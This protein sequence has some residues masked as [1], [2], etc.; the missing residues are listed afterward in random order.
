[1]PQKK[2]EGGCPKEPKHPG[3]TPPPPP[4]RFDSYIYQLIALNVSI[5]NILILINLTRAVQNYASYTLLHAPSFYN[6]QCNV[7]MQ[8]TICMQRHFTICLQ[9]HACMSGFSVPQYVLFT[10]RKAF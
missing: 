3:G 5:P 4:P 9:P 7:I 2:I 8:F 10:P 1:M 6:M